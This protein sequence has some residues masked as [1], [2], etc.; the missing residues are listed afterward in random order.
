MFTTDKFKRTDK[1]VFTE[2]V[3]ILYAT[4]ME[5]LGWPALSIAN[6]Q[7]FQYV[8]LKKLNYVQIL[9]I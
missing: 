5:L 8:F 2:P 9:K 1:K 3:K 6:L 7:K 4:R